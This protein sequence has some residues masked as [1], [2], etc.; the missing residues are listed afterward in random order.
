MSTSCAGFGIRKYSRLL[1][2]ALGSSAAIDGA[3][4]GAPPLG[5]AAQVGCG[6]SGVALE[7]LGSGGPELQDKRAST[8]YLVWRNGVPRVLV[9]SGG[10]S[11]LRFG[12]SGAT[13][14]DL[15]VILL[16]HLHVDHTAD[17]TALVKSSFFEER[18]RTLPVYGPDGNKIFP[19]TRRF[20]QTLF[21]GPNGA[22]RYLSDVVTPGAADSYLI[23]AHNVV[24]GAHEVRQI[25]ERRGTRIFATP[26]V[27][28]GVPDR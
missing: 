9:D 15:D 5:S 16:T 17:L 2:I 14:S 1:A 28:G 24:P 19:S 25:Y 10:G 6:P 22:Y 20:I 8:S 26:V 18:Q 4:V 3:A 21:A 13:M 27:H 12:E 7:V 23:D 11:A